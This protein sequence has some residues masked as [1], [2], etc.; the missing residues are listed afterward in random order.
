MALTANG[1]RKL[2]VEEPEF[3]NFSAEFREGMAPQ[4]PEGLDYSRLT[5]LLIE[6]VK[7]QQVQLKRQQNQL[8]RLKFELTQLRKQVKG[9]K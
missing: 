7:Q 4:P 1:L 5:A 3:A 9:S 2:G 6:A 8:G